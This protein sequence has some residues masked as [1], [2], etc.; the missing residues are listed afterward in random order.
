MTALFSSLQIKPELVEILK[1]DGITE[2]TPIQEKAIPIIFDGKDVIAQAQTGTGKTLAFVLPMLEKIDPNK[3]YVQGLIITPTREL[4]IQIT[5]EIKKMIG[6][7]GAKVLA[8]YGGQDVEG[9]IHKLKA[10]PHVVVATPGRLLD[11]LRRGTI[12]IQHI[13]MLVLDE[14]DQMLEM[15]FLPE[16]QAIIEQAPRKRQTL[17]FSATIS[18]S[19]RELA[20]HYTKD[21]EDIKVEGKSITLEGIKQYAVDTTDRGKQ[22]ALIQ[23]LERFQPFLAVIFCRTKIRAKKLTEVLITQGMNVDELHGDLSQSKREQV[24]KKFRKADLQI[25][26][27]TDV[28][29]RGLDVE[30]VSHVF[31]YDIPPDAENYIHRIGR[32]GRAGHSGMSITFVT[33]KDRQTLALI[34]KGIK[35]DLERSGMEEFSTSAKQTIKS[36]RSKGRNDSRT[37]E[38]PERTRRSDGVPDKRT[39]KGQR[40]DQTGQKPGV[41]PKKPNRPNSNKDRQSNRSAQSTVG[42]Q[43]GRGRRR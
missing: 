23:M 34:E 16:V 33:Q 12:N 5:A 4:A 41:K 29:A 9:Q 25:L 8:A 26:V 30:G 17:L 35:M 15:G 14:A 13:S 1:K 6:V 10:S 24:M 20:I 37:G 38:R 11:H 2:A 32:T 21:A 28:A 40:P 36:N 43:G 7:V 3:P 27:A 19:V 42:A 39:R 18:N 22:K 31:N